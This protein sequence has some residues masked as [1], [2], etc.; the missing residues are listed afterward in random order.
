MECGV[1]GAMNST[2][3]PI[4]QQYITSDCGYPRQHFLLAEVMKPRPVQ[5]YQSVAK[6]SLSLRHVLLSSFDPTS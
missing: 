6:D 1:T 2:I 5:T 4:A 3:S